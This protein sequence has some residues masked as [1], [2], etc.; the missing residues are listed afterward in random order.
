M[1]NSK[2]LHKHALPPIMLAVGL[3]VIA[4]VAISSVVVSRED[5]GD[6][7]N[8]LFSARLL[9]IQPTSNGLAKVT[10]AAPQV[11]PQDTQLSTGVADD[12]K[13][14]LKLPGDTINLRITIDAIESSL[15]Q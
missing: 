3:T 14:E 6:T 11:L 7:M 9:Q 10:Y 12:E 5:P 4:F 2:Q 1:S 8:S 13:P 15:N